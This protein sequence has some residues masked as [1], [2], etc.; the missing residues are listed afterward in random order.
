MSAQSPTVAPAS[1]SIPFTE[2]VTL[3]QQVFVRHGTSP[4]VALVLAHNCASAERDGAH[5][6]GVFRIPGYVSTL[7]SGWVSGKAVPVVEDVASGFV[8]VDA[9]NGFAQ[10]ALAA[11]R[12]LLV[13]K[14]RSAGIALLAIRNSHHFAA[15]WPDVEPFAEE[16]LV[17]LSVVNSMTCVVPHGADRPLFGTNPIAFAAPRADGPPI[18][19]DLATSAIAHGDVQIAA[20]KGERLPLGTGVDSLGQPTQDPKAILEGGALL[21]FG[22]HKGSAL[23][24]MVELLAAALTGGNFSFEFDWSNHPGART[25]WTGQLLIVIDPAKTAGQG[26]AERSQELVRQMHAAGLRRLPGDRRHRTREKS[27]QEGIVLEVEVL[28]QLRE[29]AG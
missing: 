16:G 28:Q 6:H 15:L 25:P 2:L 17:A 10:P 24:M 7:G 4:E 3:L 27:L 13:E 23:S 14:A 12:S 11:A 21:P 18:V 29:L 8:R 26:F 19:F 5:S 22:G 9:D 1:T 20:R